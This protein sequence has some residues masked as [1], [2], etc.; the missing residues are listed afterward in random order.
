MK[1]SVSVLLVRNVVSL[2]IYLASLS[3]VV[4]LYTI[5]EAQKYFGTRDPVQIVS[6][7]FEAMHDAWKLYLAPLLCVANNLG[8][9][10]ENVDSAKQTYV[11]LTVAQLN[12]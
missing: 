12:R 6:Q 3:H 8:L 5:Q 10:G 2:T 9:E 7:S 1:H 11:P 4:G